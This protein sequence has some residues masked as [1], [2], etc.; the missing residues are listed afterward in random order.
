MNILHSRYQYVLCILY[1]DYIPSKWITYYN[2]FRL[3]NSESWN[4]NKTEFAISEFRRYSENVRKL[5]FFD[6]IMSISRGV[7]MEKMFIRIQIRIG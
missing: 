6:Q 1:I 7:H 4:P 3:E 5:D 2:N